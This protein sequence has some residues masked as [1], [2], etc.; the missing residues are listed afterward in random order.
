[1]GVLVDQSLTRKARAL[2]QNMT[3]AEKKLWQAVRHR[4]VRCA[5]F[6]RQVPLGHFII[7]FACLESRLVVEVDG[8]QHNENHADARRDAWLKL[9]GFRVL[10]FWNNDVL[11]SLSGVLET[12]AAA[13]QPAPPSRP[14]PVKGEGGARLMTQHHL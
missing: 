4:Q 13:L 2:R 1:M 6:R 3:N 8:G 7:D 9:S 10:R 12:I 5:R 14:S 11:E